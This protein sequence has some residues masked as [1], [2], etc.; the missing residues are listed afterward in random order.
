MKVHTDFS[1]Y[2]DI[3]NPV[4]TVGTF[5]GVH[6][7]HQ[8]I[9][10]RIKKIASSVNGETVLLTFHPHPR[11]VLFNDNTVKLIH[12][13]NE[14]IQ[15]LEKKGLDHLVIYP[16]TRSF[17]TY[18]AQKY[19][20]EL[21]VNKL[22]THT[23]VIG[24]DHHFGNDRKGN[25]ELLDKLKDKY[26]YN[27]EEISVHEIDEIKVSSTKVRNAIYSGDIHLVPNYTGYP[28]HFS[29]IIIKGDGIGKT[30]NYPTANISLSSQEKIIP[31]KGV[32]AV[33][34][35]LKN[36]K[37]CHGIMNIGNRPTI[38]INQNESIEI[39]LFDFNKNIYGETLKVDVI[40]KI[41]E[42]IKFKNIEALKT[43]IAKD[44]V[45]ATQILSE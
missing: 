31:N 34:C 37:H 14:K 20:E 44:C 5:D 35:E 28:F 11:K 25:I 19:V 8:K 21:I 39:H 29:G 23:L 41:R 38:G 13:L 18:S 7:G 3:K 27:L 43:Q 4:V 33:K 22:K 6:L 16:F 2:I 42:E 1:S 15:V 30:I 9:L 10:N 40:K 26:H 17:S 24:Y 12:T 36:K 45:K 32:Y